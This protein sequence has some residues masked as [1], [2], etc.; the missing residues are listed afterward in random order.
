MV[1]NSGLEVSTKKEHM[2]QLA[3]YRENTLRKSPELRS[4]FIELTAKCN[5]FFASAKAD[6]TMEE[7]A[8]TY[9][10][11]EALIK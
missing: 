6:G 1:C 5:E 7:I 4:L 11:Q 10:V 8:K 2:E 3:E 9:G